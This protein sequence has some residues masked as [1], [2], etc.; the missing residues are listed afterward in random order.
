MTV[1]D[2]RLPCFCQD[3]RGQS[4]PRCR[5]A[6]PEPICTCGSDCVPGPFHCTGCPSDSKGRTSGEREI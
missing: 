4:C 2:T 5:A 3:S 6:R 1:I